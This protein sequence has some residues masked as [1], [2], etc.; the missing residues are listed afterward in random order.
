MVYD[1][2]LAELQPGSS[3]LL[4]SLE[5]RLAGWL[6]DPALGRHEQQELTEGLSADAARKPKIFRTLLACAVQLL[7]AQSCDLDM[8]SALSRH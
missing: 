1:L 4:L 2:D 3:L 7:A 5:P 8:L 6:C